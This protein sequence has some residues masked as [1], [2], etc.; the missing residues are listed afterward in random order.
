MPLTYEP[1][2]TT[3]LGSNQATVTFSSISSS[4]TDLVIIC[5]LTTDVAGA[6][7]G[8]ILNGDTGTNYSVTRLQGRGT[9]AGSGRSSNTSLMAAVAFN[10]LGTSTTLPAFARINIFSYAGSTH[11]TV[12]TE[13]GNE[14]GS[15]G[16]ATRTVGLWRNTAAINS[17]QITPGSGVNFKTGSVFT[18]YGIARA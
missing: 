3:T 11:K 2:S 5:S 9:T 7:I 1:L 10:T 16:E 18:L 4:Y 15:D 8:L 6:G 14:Q 17:V 13:S 12:L